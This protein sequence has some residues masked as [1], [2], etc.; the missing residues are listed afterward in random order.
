M[1]NRNHPLK[2][3]LSI[4]VVLLLF[5]GAVFLVPGHWFN[6]FVAPINTSQIQ[7]TN[8]PD[9]WMNILP[10][11]VVESVP[12]E[13]KQPEIPDNP[14]Q[15]PPLEAPGWWTEGWRIQAVQ[16]SQQM[17]P[18]ATVD[19]VAVVMQA[20]GVG[21]DFTRKVLPDSVLAHKL[22]ILQIEDGFAFDELKPYLR[23]MTKARALLDINSRAADMYDEHLGSTIMVPD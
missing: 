3:P 8:Q 5:F 22:L 16:E 2:W 14:P 11:L 1:R 15:R 18:R 13:K 17:L 6:F 19:S 10:P 7:Q 21:L 20:L 23:A 4:C 12:A 9:Q